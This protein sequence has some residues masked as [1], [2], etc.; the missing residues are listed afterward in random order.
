MGGIC[1][2]REEHYELVTGFDGKIQ[3]AYLLED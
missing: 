1:S 2:T 3:R